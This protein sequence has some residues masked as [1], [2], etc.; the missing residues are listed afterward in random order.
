ME[1][2]WVNADDTINHNKKVIEQKD[3]A[4]GYSIDFLRNYRAKLLTN[5]IDML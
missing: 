4:M 2:G 5:S 3:P 1:A